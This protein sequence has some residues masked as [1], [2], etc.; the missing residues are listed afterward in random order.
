MYRDTWISGTNPHKTPLTIVVRVGFDD[1]A[2]TRVYVVPPGGRWS[3]SL[4]NWHPAQTNASIQIRADAWAPT[5]IALWAGPIGQGNP[6]V[7]RP[8]WNCVEK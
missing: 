6:M 3:T 8:E 7:Y 4:A 1:R 5:E 2:E